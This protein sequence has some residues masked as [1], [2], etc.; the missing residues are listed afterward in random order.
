[1]LT[2]GDSKDRAELCVVPH[3]TGV[4]VINAGDIAMQIV[5]GLEARGILEQPCVN[6]WG[7]AD[8]RHWRQVARILRADLISAAE[9]RTEAWCVCVRVG[10]SVCKS[11][12]KSV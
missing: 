5:L 6:K 4:A 1:M 3:K 2:V 11:V 10:I 12:C 9:S 8:K 7:D